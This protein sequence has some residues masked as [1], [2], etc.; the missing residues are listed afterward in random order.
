MEGK[1]K[2]A[3]FTEHFDFSQTSLR[4]WFL[5][6]VTL[7]GNGESQTLDALE[8]S[9]KESSVVCSST[10]TLAVLQTDIRESRRLQASDKVM[11]K[12]YKLYTYT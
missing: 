4:N 3:T 9:K 7:N 6:H 10:G 12:L 2:N 5:S 11:G 8:L 1:E